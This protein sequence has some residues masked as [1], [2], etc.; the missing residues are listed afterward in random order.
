MGPAFESRRDHQKKCSDSLLCRSIFLCELIKRER[1]KKRSV[2]KANRRRQAGATAPSESEQSRRD[3]PDSQPAFF[4]TDFLIVISSA[5]TDLDITVNVDALDQTERKHQRQHDRAA[6]GNHR[7]RHA[8][9]GQ[10]P[11]HHGNIDKNI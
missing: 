11:H 7:Q 4:I 5:A 6:V 10:K 2:S 3:H 1:G 8:H 9:N